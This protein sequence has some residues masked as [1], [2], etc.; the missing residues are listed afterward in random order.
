[1]ASVGNISG[2]KA[3]E[4]DHA[5]ITDSGCLHNRAVADK[6]LQRDNAFMRKKNMVDWLICVK[7]NLVPIKDDVFN[8]GLQA[9]NV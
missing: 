7:K 4:P 9:G 1:L 5:F 3:A 8:L 6:D 2:K